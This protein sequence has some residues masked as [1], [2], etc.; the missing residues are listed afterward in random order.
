METAPQTFPA[1]RWSV[2]AAAGAGAGPA[3]EDL[4][5]AYWFPLYAYVRRRGYDASDAEDLVQEFFLALLERG[6][7]AHACPE[8]GRF[9]GFLATA[10]RHFLADAHDHATAAKRDRRRLVWLDGL[11]AEQRYHIEPVSASTAEEAFDRQWAL[12]LLA[13]AADDLAAEYTQRGEAER[14]AI[15]RPALDDPERA[16]SEALAA[17]LGCTPG[18]AKVAL[19]RLRHRWREHL[20]ARIADTVADPAEVDDEVM[21]LLA[22]LGASGV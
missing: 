1:T 12:A 20:R 18:A 14:F 22:A 3:L 21:H 2:V 15:L 19:H 7:M 13:A 8:R 4:C 17:A 5:Q 9:R 11:A 10:L 16:E 6:T